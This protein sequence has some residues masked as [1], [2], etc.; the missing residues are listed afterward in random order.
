MEVGAGDGVGG[1]EWTSGRHAG[2]RVASELALTYVSYDG[3]CDCLMETA[4]LAGI[5]E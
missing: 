3:T 1:Q 4:T 2:R 5:G